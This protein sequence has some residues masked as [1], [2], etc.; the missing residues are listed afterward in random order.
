MDAHMNMVLNIYWV[1]LWKYIAVN[2][3]KNIF[4]S[5]YYWIVRSHHGLSRGAAQLLVF[6]QLISY[7]KPFCKI[8]VC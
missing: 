2:L 6:L 7:S 4:K 8:H 3:K 1:Y 5:T